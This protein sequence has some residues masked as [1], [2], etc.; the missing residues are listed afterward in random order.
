MAF[1][2]RGLEMSA[3]GQSSMETLLVIGFVLVVSAAILIPFTYQQSLTNAAL[4]AKLEVLPYMDRSPST[5]QITTITPQFASGNL[6]LD[7]QSRGTLS[8]D[9]IQ[10]IG[11]S[12][13][14]TCQSMCQ[15]VRQA[16]TFQSISFTWT[17]TGAPT[18]V[19][20][21]VSC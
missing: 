2:S 14:P 4:I 15:E 8:W 9:S 21:N 7:V 6:V 18:Q 17:H 16:S 20:C 12:N 11:A 1:F 19:M 5:A 3:R 13:S 10:S